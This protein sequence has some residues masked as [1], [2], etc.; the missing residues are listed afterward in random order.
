[1]PKTTIRSGVMS[2]PP[3]MPVSPTSVPTPSPKRTMSGSTGSLLPVQPAFRLLCVRPA[4]GPA[5]R[6]NR[7]VG[8]PDR[9]V[10]AIVERV[11]RQA[12]LVDV[13]PHPGL[14]PIRE[15]VGLPEAVQ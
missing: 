5:A 15:R 12:V 2:D 11:V 4:T 1:M 3:P 13:G 7:A 8:A 9:L 10:A 6:G 14:A